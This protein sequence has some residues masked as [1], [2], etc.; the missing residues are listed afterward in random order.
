MEKWSVS[1]ALLLFVC[2]TSSPLYSHVLKQEAPPSSQGKSL[3]W[4]KTKSIVVIPILL[5]QVIN[6]GLSICCN[7]ANA[8]S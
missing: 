8:M 2:L 7:L 1:R 5:W 3:N 6:L 4:S